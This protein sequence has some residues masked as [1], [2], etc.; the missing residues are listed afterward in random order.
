MIICQLNDYVRQSIIISGYTA[1]DFNAI[2]TRQIIGIIQCDCI[3]RTTRRLGPVQV[4]KQV[5]LAR[6]RE[7]IQALRKPTTGYKP[8]RQLCFPKKET[9]C[10][11]VNARATCGQSKEI[12]LHHPVTVNEWPIKMKSLALC[13]T[14]NCSN[15]LRKHTMNKFENNLVLNEWLIKTGVEF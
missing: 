6:S 15:S 14:D 4:H 7:R 3:Y 10:S 9:V 5:K 2:Q 13:A 12:G 8:N 1:S 11:S